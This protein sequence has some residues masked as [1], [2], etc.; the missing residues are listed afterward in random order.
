MNRILWPIASCRCNSQARSNCTRARPD[1]GSRVREKRSRSA[2]PT[3]DT[4]VLN[5]ASSI[6]AV[7]GAH[8]GIVQTPQ[9]FQQRIDRVTEICQRQV[10]QPPLHAFA[11]RIQAQV[12]RF[13]KVFGNSEVELG[14]SVPG[15]RI[16]AI[17]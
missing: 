13:L 5:V 11:A 7:G 6:V 12:A 9:H 15:H 1:T 4:V 17:I 8:A 3:S 16:I 10:C 14:H 2:S